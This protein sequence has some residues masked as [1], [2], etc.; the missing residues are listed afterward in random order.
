MQRFLSHK[1]QGCVVIPVIFFLYSST[2]AGKCHII[3][4]PQQDLFALLLHSPEQ[5]F[6]VF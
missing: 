5:H 6:P 4:A 1:T 3:S 2:R